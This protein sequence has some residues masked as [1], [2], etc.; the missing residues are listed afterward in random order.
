MKI[1]KRVSIDEKTEDDK[2]Q[3]RA[4]VENRKVR[5]CNF[6]FFISLYRGVAERRRNQKF[7]FSFSS[8]NRV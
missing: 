3:T 8:Y 5:G 2:L 7:R 4:V 6:S 1:R